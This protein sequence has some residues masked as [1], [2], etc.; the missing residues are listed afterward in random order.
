MRTGQRSEHSAKEAAGGS[1]TICTQ[2]K[3]FLRKLVEEQY[4]INMYDCPMT[5]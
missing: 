5:N 4:S 1:T 2:S 3:Q